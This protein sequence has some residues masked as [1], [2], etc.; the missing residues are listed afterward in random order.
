MAHNDYTHLLPV[1]EIITR[2][3]KSNY[4]DSRDTP[5]FQGRV[6]RVDKSC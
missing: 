6:E 4:I 5:K 1:V 3:C 2:I